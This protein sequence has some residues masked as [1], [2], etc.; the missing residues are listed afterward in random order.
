MSEFKVLAPDPDPALTGF[1]VEKS[2][3]KTADAALNAARKVAKE[4]G[5]LN[6][7]VL[8]EEVGTNNAWTVHYHPDVPVATGAVDEYGIPQYAFENEFKI[9][10]DGSEEQYSDP[11]PETGAVTP[12][13]LAGPSSIDYEKADDNA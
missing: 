6:S 13:G 7:V 10:F 5:R 4:D 1:P 9:V 8:V 12:Q 11:D 3:H 2:S